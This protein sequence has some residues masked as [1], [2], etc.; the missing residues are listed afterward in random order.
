MLNFFGRKKKNEQRI[1]WQKKSAQWADLNFS[2]VVYRFW[3]NFQPCMI[4]I[5]PEFSDFFVSFESWHDKS[6]ITPK[7]QFTF[8]N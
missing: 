1:L 4:W 2:D 6:R 3:L 5:A 8:N 7:K